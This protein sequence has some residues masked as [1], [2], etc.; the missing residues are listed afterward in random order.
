MSE[1]NFLDKAKDIRKGE[2]FDIKKLEAYLSDQVA[3][4]PGIEK[5]HQFPG[6]FSNLTYLIEDK[7]KKE[8][9]LRRPP[10]GAKIKSAHDMG[11]EFK[12]LS[13]LQPHFDKIPQPIVHCEEEDIIGAP[14]YMM[15]RLSG[16]I[17]RTKIPQ[18]LDLGADNMKTLSTSAIETMAQL[19]NIDLEETGLINFGKP[20]GYIQRQVDGWIRRYY[21]SQT[22]DIVE[23][24]RLAEWMKAN[25]PTS[26]DAAFIHN[27]YKYDNLIL[28]PDDLSIKGVLDWEMAT[29]GHP[30]M[31]FGTTLGY[32]S[33]AKDD[34]LLKFF[35][36]TWLDGNLNRREITEL[37]QEKTGKEVDDI[38]FYYVFGLFK[39]SVICQ[40]IYK[41]FKDGYSKDPRFA[42]LINIIKAMSKG[43]INALDR[44]SVSYH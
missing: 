41:R 20:D 5:V 38:L 3:G 1:D 39:I 37:Y 24:D 18:G 16:I 8:Y 15:T 22:D 30:L 9:V 44:D 40:Q 36:L 31:D 13:L 33:E 27:D 4:F 10:F 7:S 34:N 6:G 17:L 29:V 35:N 42:G 23:M 19:H 25:Q 12:V 21:K 14:F 11:R 2:E 32:W 43:G 26:N 28:S